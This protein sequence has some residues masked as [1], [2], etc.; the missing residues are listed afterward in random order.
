M[1]NKN[2]IS[3]S[4][5]NSKMGH[6]P[7]VS[8][9]PIITCTNCDSCAQKCYANK[10]CRIYPSVKNAYNRNLEILKADRENYFDQIKAT[11]KISAFFRFHVSGDIIDIDYFS[12]MCKLSRDCKNTKFLV[13]TKNYNVVNEY[14]NNHRK[15][16][17]FTDRKCDS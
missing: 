17:Q 11:A 13:F 15:P 3:I 7:S 2:Q 6:I 14:L 9:P 1:T 16:S 10:L 8:L 5:G 12:R 4:N